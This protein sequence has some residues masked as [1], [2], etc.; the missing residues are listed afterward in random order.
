MRKRADAAAEIS[1]EGVSASDVPT[2]EQQIVAKQS[3]MTEARAES[4]ADT[5]E[6][7]ADEHAKLSA[8]LKRAMRHRQRGS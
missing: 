5:Y 6:R 8:A 1:T 4:D 2:L 7:L 3:E